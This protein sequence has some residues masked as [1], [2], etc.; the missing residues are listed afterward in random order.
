MVTGAQQRQSRLGAGPG[1]AITHGRVVEALEAEQP[2][3]GTVALK[4]AEMVHPAPL[5]ADNSYHT[6]A[7]A[8]NDWRR[9]GNADSMS[10]RA[11]TEPTIATGYTTAGASPTGEDQAG[12][13]HAP[14]TPFHSQSHRTNKETL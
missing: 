12:V 11:A 8:W 13:R 9:I 10:A 3:P 4:T 7:G 5:V 14:I 1:A 6:L 2:L